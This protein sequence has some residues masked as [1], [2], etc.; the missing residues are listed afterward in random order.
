MSIH[1][2]VLE[3]YLATDQIDYYR[4]Y[5]RCLLDTFGPAYVEHLERWLEA[6]RVSAAATT[7]AQATSPPSNATPARQP[8]ALPIANGSVVIPNFLGEA[9]PEL[10]DRERP[11]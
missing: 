7:A 10:R 4:L 6:D 9:R 2:R 11:A 3:H 8:S 5:N 1:R